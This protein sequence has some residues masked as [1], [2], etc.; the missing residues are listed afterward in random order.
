MDDIS[1]VK[2]YEHIVNT[3]PMSNNRNEE[4]LEFESFGF[5]EPLGNYFLPLC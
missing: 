2:L 1:Y 3:H 5:R 4:T